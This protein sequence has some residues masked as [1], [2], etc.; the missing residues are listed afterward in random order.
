MRLD[1]EIFRY[2]SK[3]DLRVLQALEVGHKNH[4]LV[5]LQLVESIAGL[6][7]GGCFKTLQNLLKHKLVAHDGKTYDGYK[8]TYNGYD[9]LA[10]RTL[11]SRGNIA[12]VG[13]R[14]GVGKESDI[15]VCTDDEGRQLVIKFHRLGRVSF[16]TVKENRDYLQHRQSASWMY[17]ARLAAAKEYA[18]L[19]ELYK[20]GFPVPE[21]VGSNRHAIV[22]EYLDDATPMCQI[23]KLEKPEILLE[24]CMSLLLSIAQSGVIHGDF[25][26]FNLLIRT[27]REDPLDELSEVEDYEVYVID[28]PQV[29]SV[30]NPD[31]KRIFERDVEC[32]ATYFAKNHKYVVDTVPSFEDDVLP[33]YRAKTKVDGINLSGVITEGEDKLLMDSC[34]AFTELDQEDCPD[35][36]EGN[37]TF[38]D[39][40][41]EMEG[42]EDKKSP[43]ENGGADSDEQGSTAS[44][45]EDRDEKR[46]V[47]KSQNH[48]LRRQRRKPQDKDVRA[49][50]NR[51]LRSK[52]KAKPNVQKS[53]E[54]RQN[55]REIKENSSLASLANRAELTDVEEKQ[56]SRLKRRQST[57]PRVSGGKPEL[58]EIIAINAARSRGIHRGRTSLASLTP[59]ET[60]N[61][62]RKGL[63]VEGIVQ[64][65]IRRE[66]I[67]PPHHRQF[68]LPVARP[69]KVHRKRS[70]G[71]QRRTSDVGPTGPCSGDPDGVVSMRR[72]EA[73]PSSKRPSNYSRRVSVKKVVPVEA[74]NTLRR[75]GAK[76]SALKREDGTIDEQPPGASVQDGCTL[77]PSGAIRRAQSLGRGLTFPDTDIPFSKNRAALMA[78]IAREEGL[79]SL[80]PGHLLSY[81]DA[82]QNVEGKCFSIVL[83][84]GNNHGA[85]ER[86]LSRTRSWWRV[87]VTHQGSYSEFCY[88]MFNLKWK[89]SLP[90]ATET[91]RRMAN[92]QDLGGTAV[93]QPQLVNYFG[94]C[95][96]LCTKAALLRNLA[97]YCGEVNINLWDIIPVSI[98]ISLKR[99]DHHV[100]VPGE[101][102]SGFE[103]FTLATEIMTKVSS[104]GAAEEGTADPV[105]DAPPRKDDICIRVSSNLCAG[106]N[107]FLLRN[108]MDQPHNVSRLISSRSVS[109]TNLRSSLTVKYSM[110]SCFV[111][112]VPDVEPQWMLKPAALSR[113]RGIKVIRT[114]AELRR[115][116]FK[117]DSPQCKM[118]RRL[119]FPESTEV[120][121]LRRAR[122]SSLGPVG[123]T[124]I[125]EILDAAI[126]EVPQ[127]CNAKKA[128]EDT[129]GPESSSVVSTTASTVPSHTKGEENADVEG[130]ECGQKE[131]TTSPAQ[132]NSAQVA[133]K[134]G[135]SKESKGAVANWVLQKY[136]DRPMLINR[137][138]FD[139]RMWLVLT[140]TLHA[141]C[142]REGYVRTASVQYDPSRKNGEGDKMMHL[143][144]N[145]IQKRGDNY[146]QYE[147][148][149]QMSFDDL[150]AYAD[151]N[152]GGPSCPPRLDVHGEMRSAMYRAM[153]ISLHATLR[154]F[155]SPNSNSF[156]IFGY[157]FMIDEDGG[158]WLIEVNSN[159][160]LEESSTIL[161]KYVP[162]M[163]N[164]VFSLCVDP[165]ARPRG[166]AANRRPEWR[167]LCSSDSDCSVRDKFD[168]VCCGNVPHSGVAG[169]DG[170]A[171]LRGS[172][173]K[174]GPSARTSNKYKDESFTCKWCNPE[175]TISK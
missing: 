43:E 13:Q 42:D 52:N 174:G 79:A 172:R 83:C 90:N 140:P 98:I 128:Q 6:K 129:D 103:D 122:S 113:G 34:A 9:F 69:R 168:L 8:L 85:I 64:P 57:I 67:A 110:P 159:P 35:L 132:G 10:L 58:P 11:M 86:M 97:R 108:G 162:E 126:S 165:Y 23:R 72:L 106:S 59:R 1:C 49:K 62:I 137:R 100:A 80:P 68:P 53:R 171:R 136:I 145:A 104:C 134:N 91:L 7:R 73:Q 77:N 82:I 119:S 41:A 120:N 142:Y 148:G 89:Q 14:V 149:N 78:A 175:Q 88:S 111:P 138:K 55:Q 130:T 28:F 31:A 32:I 156:Q 173:D 18:Y 150:Q 155:R 124:E 163:L 125:K 48:V 147:D 93:C 2:L 51:Q 105:D 40:L 123:K 71:Q 114:A 81:S 118:L 44:E 45:W 109:A 47:I 160:C 63:E 3:E 33:V 36:A 61:D 152:A 151:E 121:D 139:I 169:L 92:S 56:T 158:V 60:V 24:R 17:L 144:N 146:G 39:L 12:G 143:C 30:E 141:Y 107:R 96:E 102:S 54:A 37:E 25:N 167:K 87:V 27:V 5:P 50:V 131:T 74:V 157:D 117:R 127:L 15:H 26:E 20:A 116:V 94:G 19:T 84:A 66:S 65:L 75:V 115:A 112:A 133:A 46:R 16:K 99:T 154:Q 153:A 166:S 38:E 29:L 101:A 164:G 4:E 21:P 135:K 76:P 170:T 22:M 161:E 70:P 95:H